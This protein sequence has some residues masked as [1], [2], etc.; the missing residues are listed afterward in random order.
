MFIGKA[1]IILLIEFIKKKQYKTSEYILKPKPLG[2]NVKV[3]LDLTNYVTK[4]DLKIQ[5][6]LNQILLKKVDLASLKLEIDKLD[7]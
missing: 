7:N 5:Q 1:I 4:V 3:K 2:G 6:V